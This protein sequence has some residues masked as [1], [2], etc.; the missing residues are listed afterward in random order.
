MH[1]EFYFVLV[2]CNLIVNQIG[3]CSM[4]SYILKMKYCQLCLI[5][6]LRKY[7]NTCDRIEQEKVNIDIKIDFFIFLFL[8]NGGLKSICQLCTSW[9]HAYNAVSVNLSMADG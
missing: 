9:Y 6:S 8:K 3:C 4:T 1:C 2:V 7:E 5:Q